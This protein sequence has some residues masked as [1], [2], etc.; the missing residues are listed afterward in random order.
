M[1]QRITC[2]RK[3]VCCVQQEE[4]A[5]H[6][7]AREDNRFQNIFQRTSRDAFSLA[8]P[9][10]DPK[11][12][13]IPNA[14]SIAI[15]LSTYSS[16]SNRRSQRADSPI[17]ATVLCTHQQYRRAPGLGKP[18]CG[19]FP[20]RLESRESARPPP[21]RTSTQR[22]ACNMRLPRLRLGPARCRNPRTLRSPWFA[23][24]PGAPRIFPYRCRPSSQG[25]Q[26]P[27]CSRKGSRKSWHSPRSRPLDYNAG[28]YG[29]PPR[30][31]PWCRCPDDGIRGGKWFP[32]WSSC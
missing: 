2:Q 24:V 11:A 25:L 23:S 15:R 1:L 21:P 10:L 28:H 27:S 9:S 17:H 3:P 7:H 19:P 20:L 8:G 5:N 4:C 13:A 18:P 29:P 26:R 12:K 6:I 31:W 32:E 22:T 16:R 14:S 30:R